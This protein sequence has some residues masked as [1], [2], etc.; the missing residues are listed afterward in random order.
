MLS[1][2]DRRSEVSSVSLDEESATL[3]QFEKAYQVMARF[4]G[5]VDKMADIMVNLGR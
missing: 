4:M 5:V 2:Q 1:L 3:I